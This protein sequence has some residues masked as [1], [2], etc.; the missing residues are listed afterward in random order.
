M[1]L[2][3]SFLVIVYGIVEQKKILLFIGG[4][5]FNREFVMWVVLRAITITGCNMQIKSRQALTHAHVRR[6]GMKEEKE[7]HIGETS[8]QDKEC[9]G[10]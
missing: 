5:T 8:E 7:I 4:G 1:F 9:K 6:A 2:I 10:L 3:S